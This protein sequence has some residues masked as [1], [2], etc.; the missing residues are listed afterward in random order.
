MVRRWLQALR[1]A[2][3]GIEGAFVEDKGMAVALHDQLVKPTQHSRLRR[4][5]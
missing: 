3:Q 4:R 1:I 2:A 5:A